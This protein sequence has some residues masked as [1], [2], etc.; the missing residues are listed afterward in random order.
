MREPLEDVI[1]AGDHHPGI[2]AGGFHESGNTPHLHAQFDHALVRETRA[3]SFFAEK[4]NQLQEVV[5][6]QIRS[7]VEQHL[8][9]ERC[10]LGV[11]HDNAA[12]LAPALVLEDALSLQ[13]TQRPVH[14]AVIDPQLLLEL[15]NPR[16]FA[17]PTPLFQFGAQVERNLLNMRQGTKHP[18][19]MTNLE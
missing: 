6:L 14:H 3:V 5:V 13:Q 11:A 8:D 9:V 10:R 19:T 1:G 2:R 18:S 15:E 16:H 7:L 12:L 17:S 4:M